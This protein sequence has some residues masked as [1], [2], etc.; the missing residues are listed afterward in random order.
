[1]SR[2]TWR[3]VG[4]KSVLSFLE[5]SIDVRFK[6]VNWIIIIDQKWVWLREP[7]FEDESYEAQN[8]N[9]WKNQWAG[10]DSKQEAL[11][12]WDH[13][14]VSLSPLSLDLIVSLLLLILIGFVNLVFLTR[15]KL[16][17]VNLPELLKLCGPLGLGSFLGGKRGVQVLALSMERMDHELVLNLLLQSISSLNLVLLVNSFSRGGL[18]FIIFNEIDELSNLV[19]VEQRVVFWAFLRMV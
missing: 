9:G 16:L 10:E 14:Y 8:E 1:M 12:L 13:L 19:L 5:G 4:D 3:W 18:V 2:P 15:S 6:I 17:S 7:Q 11:L